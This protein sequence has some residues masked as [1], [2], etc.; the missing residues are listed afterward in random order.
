MLFAA[1]ALDVLLVLLLM[2][3]PNTM[4][5]MLDHPPRHMWLIPAFG[6][7]L[8]LAGLAWMIRIIRADPEAHPSSWRAL[9][10]DR[11]R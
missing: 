2:S 8:N 4:G 10:G 9:R 7:A 5:P 11:P 3:A 6:V 1:V